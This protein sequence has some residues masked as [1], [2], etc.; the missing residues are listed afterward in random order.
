MLKEPSPVLGLKPWAEYVERLR[1][2]LPLDLL[3]K[4]AWLRWR[5]LVDFKA[6]RIIKFPVP[7]YNQVENYETFEQVARYKA[8]FCGLGL[9][10][11]GLDF[12]ICDLDS[13]AEIPAE[14][15]GEP[16]Y[17]EQSPSGNGTRWWYKGR[18]PEGGP[19]V[20]TIEGVEVYRDK[21]ATVTGNVVDPEFSTR[22]LGPIP[23][24]LL[25]AW[26]LANLSLPQRKD[27]SEPG[28]WYKP[29]LLE[30]RLSL[31]K[32][33]ISGFDYLSLGD[34]FSVVCPGDKGWPD[35]SK[36]SFEEGLTRTAMVWLLNQKP[37]FHCFHAHCQSPKKTWKDF[38]SFYDPDHLYHNID[39]AIEQE[40]LKL[41]DEWKS[42]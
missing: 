32:E 37:V 7:S 15:F 16:G 30:Q 12:T 18:L 36:H 14:I 13:T 24:A 6:K 22:A 1:A 39:D 42:Q 23:P 31:W 28:R 29:E 41:E 38:Q 35:G 9:A 25:E 20:H 33:F 10:N 21:W 19:G 2:H 4:K 27:D 11:V 8:G 40:V 17:L 34:R 26:N 3:Y 5:C